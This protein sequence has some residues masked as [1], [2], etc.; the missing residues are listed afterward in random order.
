MNGI[1]V[2]VHITFIWIGSPKLHLGVQQDYLFFFFGH[3]PFQEDMLLTIF[4]NSCRY[5]LSIL[6]LSTQY[7]TCPFWL[8]D[9]EVV[10][11]PFW[12]LKDLEV[13]PHPRGQMLSSMIFSNIKINGF[14]RK[15]TQPKF[16]LIFTMSFIFYQKSKM[17]PGSIRTFWY[18]GSA[19][20][21]GKWQVRQK[22]LYL[23]KIVA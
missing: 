3:A 16:D 12:H 5:M 22:G 21:K 14:E 9:L 15:Q 23:S 11:H 18:K 7:R 10:P 13:V 20:N 19:E 17:T 2:D 8:E 6:R 4:D 1:C